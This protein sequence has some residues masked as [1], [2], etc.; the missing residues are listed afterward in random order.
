MMRLI[1]LGLLAATV[2]PATVAGV[3][4]VRICPVPQAPA[5]AV[6]ITSTP[7]TLKAL[8]GSHVAGTGW[9]S[10]GEPRVGE[11]RYDWGFLLRSDDPRFSG[12]DS[13]SPGPIHSRNSGCWFYW[14][15][16]DAGS[17]A[18]SSI[19]NGRIVASPYVE[20]YVPEYPDGVPLK[21][22]G[23]RY[24]GA[25]K[26]FSPDYR[27]VGLWVAGKGESTKIFAFD[28]LRHKLLA[29]V[30]FRLAAIATLP[31][32]DTPWLAMTMVGEGEPG[33]P[34]PYFRL[35]WASGIAE[36]NEKDGTP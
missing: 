23:Y 5:N 14:D 26:A 4:G 6:P 13:T 1:T 29:E 36:P 2:I 35:S 15:I 3:S 19:S 8:G 28:G 10:P 12:F 24:A 18:V 16:G 17:G 27:W 22:P 30:P 21:I 7:L 34:V 25:D 32:P 20:S 33:K 31:S 9:P 11:L